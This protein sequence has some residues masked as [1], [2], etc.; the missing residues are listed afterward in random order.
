MCFCRPAFK[1]DGSVTAANSSKLNDG[2]AAFVVMSAGKAKELGL[3]PLFKIRGFG[4]AT[5][6]PVEF[7][8]APADAV[9]RALAHAGVSAKDVEY[10]EINEAF[11]LVAIVNAQLLNLDIDRVNVHGGAVS[12]GH[13]I[14]MSGARIVG[15]SATQ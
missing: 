3:K 7:T 4:D 8:T 2:A 1:K 13:P 9:P 10:H 14:G 11:S 5:R 15:K 6:A 12:L